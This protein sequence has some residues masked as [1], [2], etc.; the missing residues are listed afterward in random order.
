M[1]GKTGEIVLQSNEN[2]LGT[3]IA[4]Q[5]EILEILGRGGMG[6]V[7]KCRSQKTGE[8]YA[9][10]LLHSHLL[11]DAQA[12]KRFHQE[13]EAA[14]RILH[15]NAINIVDMGALPDGRPYLV[16]EF[17]D[18]I[19]L[20]EH[21]N[22]VGRLRISE[23]TPLFIQICDAL[24][25]A[26]RYGVVHR[27]IKPSNIML[28]KTGSGTYNVKVVDFGIAKLLPR[29]G[30]GTFVETATGKLIGSPPYMSPEQCLGERIDSRSDIYSLGCVIYESIMGVPPFIGNNPMETMYRHIHDAPA[31]LSGLPEDVRLVKQLDQI[32]ARVL[33]K[34][35]SKRYQTVADLRRDLHSL[36]EDSG[37]RLRPVA[38][39]QLHLEALLRKY[40]SAIGT[41]RIIIVCIIVSTLVVIAISSCFL[42]PFVV[43][44][45]P[46]A[47]QKNIDWQA[48]PPVSSSSYELNWEGTRKRKALRADIEKCSRSLG[49]V[50]PDLI[51]LQEKL[52]N[53]LFDDGDYGNAAVQYHQALESS[54]KLF[55]NT[56]SNYQG[57]P[58]IVH[59]IA[60]SSERCAQCELRLR[61]YK[62]ALRYAQSGLKWAFLD[63]S[64]D[65]GYKAY[66][67]QIQGVATSKLGGSDSVV[68]EN[69][70]S[71]LQYVK[72]RAM[73]SG[74]SRRTALALSDI[75]DCDLDSGKW[76]R[77]LKVLDMVKEAWSIVESDEVKMAGRES[78]QVELIFESAE[79]KALRRGYLKGVLH[80]GLFNEA[81]ADLKKA[82]ALQHLDDHKGVLTQFERAAEEFQSISGK[83]NINRA[84]VL[85]READFLWKEGQFFKA[86]LVRVEAVKIWSTQKR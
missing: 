49:D 48:P 31:P 5:Y 8:L 54:Q 40:G 73:K 34:S 10:K 14:S 56:Y 84:I 50:N 70:D 39:L 15:Q 37:K 62:E 18:G 22:D 41:S 32:I 74:D 26:H 53:L 29:E 21:L 12:M 60:K 43:T 20:S 17:V 25:G 45:G 51:A 72:T 67:C 35:A 19:S 38:F 6:E 4:G 33:Q 76:Q 81:V 66:F 36:L 2:L 55:I 27:D 30:D 85:F 13:A 79:H 47:A 11:M 61:Q 52:A 28:K 58:A 71:F 16:T 24:I 46:T 82:F 86:W 42:I 75:A 63:S 7:Y 3:L 57:T 65:D 78:E 44:P 69:C 80:T 1:K 9:I 23:A 77:A 59:N 64:S 83:N 68:N